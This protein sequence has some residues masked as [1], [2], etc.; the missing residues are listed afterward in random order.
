MQANLTKLNLVR[1]NIGITTGQ[2]GGP[3]DRWDHIY[4]HWRFVPAAVEIR[5]EFIK[6]KKKTGPTQP[7]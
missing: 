6:P 2:P 3:S 7:T 5:K 1:F 4:R